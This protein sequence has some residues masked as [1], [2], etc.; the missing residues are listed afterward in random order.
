MACEGRKG[1]LSHAALFMEKNISDYVSNRDVDT[2]A[3]SRSPASPALTHQR[4]RYMAVIKHEN[5]REQ[6]M[7]AH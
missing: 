6:E 4:G 1:L 7:E 2:G 3:R 5:Q